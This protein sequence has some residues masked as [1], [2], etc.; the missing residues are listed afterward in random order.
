[1]HAMRL[2]TFVVLVGVGITL[3]VVHAQEVDLRVAVIARDPPVQVTVQREDDI[4]PIVL[5]RDPADGNGPAAVWNYRGV[6]ARPASEAGT[7]SQLVAP[8]RLVASWHEAN[9]QV[10]LGLRPMAPMKLNISVYHEQISCDVNTLNAIDAFESNFDS[11][12]HKYFQARA[13]HRKWRFD[14]RQ[15]YHVAALRSARLWFDAAVA[16]VKSTSVFRMDTDIATIMSEYELRASR[17]RSFERRYRQYVPDGYIRGT[18]AQLLALDYAFVGK[19]PGLVKEGKLDQANA[20][21]E[22]ALATL[23]NSSAKVRGVVLAEQGIHRDLLNNNARY[24]ATLKAQG[25]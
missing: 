24:I 20:L 18:N 22:A 10:Y 14:Y 8:Y 16:L 13:F 11:T 1:M 23:S 21:N 6:L 9:E 15:P 19:I 4:Q 5:A 25:D 17:D 7:G 3:R 2:V 12:L